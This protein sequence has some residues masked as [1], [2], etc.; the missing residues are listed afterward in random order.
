MVFFFLLGLRFLIGRDIFKGFILP[1]F[2]SLKLLFCDMCATLSLL[3]LVN[4]LATD[5]FKS[6][7]RP[8]YFTRQ[9]SNGNRDGQNEK[10]H[11]KFFRGLLGDGVP[12]PWPP[13]VDNTLILGDICAL[14]SATLVLRVFKISRTA[15]FAA[16]GGWLAPIPIVPVSLNTLSTEISLL[17][18]CWLLAGIA[19]NTVSKAAIR[20]D[21]ADVLRAVGRTSVDF[22][23]ARLIIA[24][25]GSVMQH[26]KVDAFQVTTEIALA[27]V[28]VACWRVAAAR[29]NI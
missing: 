4:L 23:N 10:Q 28:C 24:L 16:K 5:A 14:T 12:P 29:V 18:V 9:A 1:G 15:E 26:T 6:P 25:V 22:I 7:A 20:G 2:F 17:A 21:T 27:L 8:G 3:L 11:K 13:V 19:T